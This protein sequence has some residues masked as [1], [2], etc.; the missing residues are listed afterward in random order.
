MHTNQ[1]RRAPPVID[2]AGK[3]VLITGTGG[4]QGRA[5]A[6]AFSRAGARVLG[7]DVKVEGSRETVE[8]VR[9]DGGEMLSM[10]P[11]DLSDPQQAG[12]WVRTAVER[13][14]GIDVVYNNAG[15]MRAKGPLDGSTADDF[16][17][18]IRYELTMVYIVCAAA[19]PHLKARGKGLILN[20][21][22]ISGHREF[23]PLRSVAHGAAKAGVIG[24][25]RMLA[26]EGAP[27]NI[28][29]ISIS[30][31][32]IRSPAT[33]GYWSGESP[34]LTAMGESL[35]AKVPMGRAGECEEV[36]NVAVF[37]ASEGASYING[38]DLLVDGGITGVSNS[39][40]VY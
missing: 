33:A 30:P 2:L 32:V 8:M 13:W 18:T 24:L 10:E 26:A 14:G 17:Q 16:E 25:T 29:A 28:R 7:C 36:A 15:S 37:L 34:R 21:A 38:T 40:S 31:G 12:S 9:H 35:I 23:L 20:T 5:A 3:V 27:Y 39:P 1:S 11:L 22:S 4:G 19:W 6:L